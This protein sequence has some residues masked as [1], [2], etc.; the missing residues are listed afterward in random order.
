FSNNEST[1]TAS[2]NEENGY[3]PLSKA[4]AS[5]LGSQV[6]NYFQP[7]EHIATGNRVGWYLLEIIRNHQKQTC[8]MICNIGGLTG[9]MWDQLSS[10]HGIT[11]DLN[12][13]SK[14]QQKINIMFKTSAN[15]L[16]HQTKQNQSL[17]KW[18]IDSAQALSVI[19]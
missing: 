8:N 17:V 18:I 15:N 2:D 1:E 10:I 12:L 13:K 9:N 4:S 7:L 5:K 11:K 16:K 6:W 14:D 3:K 19:V